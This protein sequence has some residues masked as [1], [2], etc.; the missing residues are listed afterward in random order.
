CQGHSRL[1]IMN[2]MP[3]RVWFGEKACR[4]GNKCLILSDALA[5]SRER[6]GE[7]INFEKPFPFPVLLG[8]TDLRRKSLMFYKDGRLKCLGAAVLL[9]ASRAMLADTV[10]SIPF[11]AEMSSSQEVGTTSNAITGDSLIWVHVIRDSA[12]VIKSGAVDFNLRC[13]FP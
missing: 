3:E 6:C 2:I 1:E 5:S 10:E 8:Q 12:G 7:R 11:L 13:R 4:C 9:L